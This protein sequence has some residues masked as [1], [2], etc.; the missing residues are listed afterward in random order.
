MSDLENLK[1]DDQLLSMMEEM[2]DQIEDLQNRLQTEV[3]KN[4]EAQKKISQLSSQISMLKNEVQKK[5]ERIEK[6]NESDLILKKNAELEK[7]IIEA[8]NKEKKTREEAKVTVEAV[9][10]KAKKDVEEAMENYNEKVASLGHRDN[11]I[12]NL[13][14][15]ITEKESNINKEITT[16]A[17]SMI[18]NQISN[19]ERDYKN[20]N[21]R[22][23]R[24][25]NDKLTRVK[26]KYRNMTMGYRSMVLTA[27]FYGILT[28]FM[29]AFK[30]NVFKSDFIEFFRNIYNVIVF[31]LECIKFI[32]NFVAKLGDMIPQ[33]RVALIVHWILVFVVFAIIVGAFV[34]IFIKASKK[35]ICFF[36]K[37]QADEISL[38]FGLAMLAIGV[39]IPDDVK[40]L[41]SI[42]IFTVIIL[43]FLV[44]T[45]F[46]WILQ[47]D[48]KERKR[49]LL[50]HS[51]ITIG[52]ISGIA[53]MVYLFGGIFFIAL[54]IGM[55]LVS[56]N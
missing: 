13:E 40:A 41:L 31:A 6:M 22:M 33:M 30:S 43:I 56:K 20:K 34:W 49:K 50:K 1:N 10:E 4:S 36:K 32:A 54:P 17:A 21:R 14:S 7:K 26:V 44:Y 38:F 23:E 2:Q 3:E 39:F 27:L 5:S 8:Q 12:I 42:N 25:Y 24:D 18:A 45:V 11:I 46:R 19:L 15:K 51:L 9:K 16:K 35:Y 28:T 29:T 52:I 47:A 48:N 53:L 55:I 37:T